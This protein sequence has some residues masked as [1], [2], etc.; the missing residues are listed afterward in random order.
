[1]TCAI[2]GCLKN[3]TTRSLCP[4]HYHQYWAADMLDQ[5]PA[6]RKTGRAPT[7]PQV[8]VVERMQ[9]GPIH[10]TLGRCI[11]VFGAKGC[12]ARIG[13]ESAARF[14]LEAALGRPIRPGYRV[15]H[16]CG[17][18]TCVRP[19]HMVEMKGCAV[20]H[21]HTAGASR[22]ESNPRSKLNDQA[23]LTMRYL[24][25]QGV[26]STRLAHAYHVSIALVSGV[27]R[28]KVWRHVQLP[29]VRQL[30]A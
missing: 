24:H 28:G 23:V 22:G 18:G 8:T 30:A 4:S 19:E 9:E 26:S 21:P 10:P 2:S 13:T 5:L 17:R 14:V 7:P 27:V 12:A 3:A 11:D 1:M 20:Y 6:K 25:E 29:D 15:H 16:L